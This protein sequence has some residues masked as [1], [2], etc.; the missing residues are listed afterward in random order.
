MTFEARIIETFSRRV[1]IDADSKDEAEEILDDLCAEG[2]I[3]LDYDDFSE[4][5]IQIV[6]SIVMGS[7]PYLPLYGKSGKIS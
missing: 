4:R 1:I 3:N 5:E 7:K 2:E 6:G